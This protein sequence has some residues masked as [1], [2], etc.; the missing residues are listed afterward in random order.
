MT[1]EPKYVETDIHGNPLT[2][3]QKQWIED[4]ELVVDEPFTKTNWKTKQA[5]DEWSD[6]F[7]RM[8]RA[9]DA[10]E[11]LSVSDDRSDRK[12]AIIH[13]RNS[14]R[15]EWLERISD[16]GLVF[17]AIRYS[18][19]YDGFSHVTRTTSK[20]DPERITYSVIA[21]NKDIADKFVEAETEMSG[22]DRHHTVGEFLAFPKCCRDFFMDVWVDQFQID[23]LY[24]I[25]CN[26]SCSEPIDGDPENILLRD[27]EPWANIFWRYFGV[28]FI[29]HLPCSVDCEDSYK[30]AKTRG[31]I[32]ADNGYREEANKLWEWL[33]EPFIWTGHNALAHIRNRY[34]IGSSGTSEY[35]SKK[36]VVWG[37]EHEPGGSIL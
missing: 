20:K 25:A 17:R 28:S 1:V 4:T 3:E 18:E 22:E 12:A 2:E 19:P 5:R 16:I 36:R 10:A 24:E 21:Q 7:Y 30:V 34:I 31:E 8:A 6:M 35:W 15:E 9:K 32:M 26:S 11:W 23:P 27:P 13:V 33:R 14:N 37:Q 29:T